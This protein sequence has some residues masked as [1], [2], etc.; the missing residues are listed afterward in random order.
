VLP[1]SNTL[2]LVTGA[3]ADL[4]FA[5]TQAVHAVYVNGVPRTAGVYGG[6]NLSPYLSG[7]GCLAVEWPPSRRT[8]LLLR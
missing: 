3:I 2:Y 7:S 6:H 4:D 1:A 5:G 8:L